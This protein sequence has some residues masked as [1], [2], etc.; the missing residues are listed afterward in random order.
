MLVPRV[1]YSVHLSQHIALSIITLQPISPRR[2]V[3]GVSRVRVST[4][5]SCMW[6]ISKD[7]SQ[8][9]H[10]SICHQ[11]NHPETKQWSTLGSHLW[12]LWWASV[13]Q[14][15]LFIIYLFLTDSFS[16]NCWVFVTFGR[17]FCCRNLK[18]PREQLRK[19]RS[20][21][22]LTLYSWW[23]FIPAEMIRQT[24]HRR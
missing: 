16:A 19:L 4:L 7:L 14:L 5:H 11:S 1:H 13:S 17:W 23:L 22:W 10:C 8:V 18:S 15:F 6:I 2:S 12:K 20:A 21:S 9:C 3:S 24:G